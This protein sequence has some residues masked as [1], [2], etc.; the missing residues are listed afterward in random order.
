[1]QMIV[2]SSNESGINRDVMF[3]REEIIIIIIVA[4]QTIIPNII[5]VNHRIGV[6]IFLMKG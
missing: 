6:Y 5:V 3:L 4:T 2:S 1:M